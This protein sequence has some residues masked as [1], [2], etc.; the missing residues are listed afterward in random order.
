MCFRNIQR[1]ASM[2]GGSCKA[3]PQFN[4]QIERLK[5]CR[6]HDPLCIW[7]IVMWLSM[8]CASAV[9][10]TVAIASIKAPSDDAGGSSDEFGIWSERVSRAGEPP[11]EETTNAA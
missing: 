4:R 9:G 3:R 6:N 2:N 8:D 1:T 10:V 11:A 7:N 5:S